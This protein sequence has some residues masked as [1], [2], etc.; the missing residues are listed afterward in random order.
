[1]KRRVVVTGRGVVSPIGN[2]V[3]EMWE[4]ILQ[5]KNG[6]DFIQQ[7]DTSK[8]KVK[9]AG[10]VKNL[11]VDRFIDPRDSKRMDRSMIMAMIAATEAYEDAKLSDATVDRD[12]FGIFIASGIGGLTTIWEESQ[13]A[14][15]RGPDRVSPFF[16]PSSIVNLVGGN[17]AIKYQIHGPAIPVVTACSAGTNAVGEAFRYIRDGYLELAFAGGSEAPLNALGLGGFTSMKALNFSNDP[18]NASIPFDKR[19]SGF[20][21]AEGSGVLVLEELEHAKRRGAPIYAEIIGYGSNCDAFHITA[22]DETADGITKCILSALKDG[23]VDPTWIDYINPHGTS[24]PYND[25]LETLGIKRA[26]KDHAYQ[27]S[28]G[29]TKSM[30]GHSLGAVGAIE[31]VIC[32]KA[33]EEDVVPPTI[34]YKEPDEDCD[35]D[36]TPN[37][38]KKRVINYA[39]S[40]SV[41]FGGQNATIILKKYQPEEAK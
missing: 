13:K 7:F 25:K 21:M 30:T 36:Y 6:I 31:A 39:M 27:L 22:P 35:L 40:N 14:I 17:I 10:E 28:I 41:G 38:A 5:G 3:K 2:T 1:M 9:I 24:T 8:N 20:V 33:I 18:N 15:E 23:N 16:I 37:V 19:R 11:D 29:G 4:S 34:N 26:F 32:V 12:R